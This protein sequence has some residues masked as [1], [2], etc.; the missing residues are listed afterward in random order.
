VRSV[1]LQR[2]PDLEYI[3]MDGGSTD[4]TQ[5]V[6][7]PYAGRFAHYVSEKDN[8]QADAL[9]RGFAL[10][11][12]EYMGYLNSDDMLAP[13]T[14]VYIADYFAA[15]PD[16][17]V[18]Y[19][20]R[21]AVNSQ[22][23]VIWYWILPEHCNYRMLRWDLIPQ[24]TCF[25]RRRIFEKCGNINPEFHFAMDYDLFARF[26]LN[27]KFKRANRFLGCFRQHDAAK[28]STQMS[29]VGQ[30]EIQRVW[31][32]YGIRSHKWDHVIGVRFFYYAERNGSKYVASGRSLPGGLAGAGYDYDQVWGGLLR[33]DRMPPD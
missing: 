27:G 9:H 1:L 7:E 25:W 22:N 11:T 4:N 17:D 19:S 24:E 33:S 12:G 2:Y 21:C 14:L 20:H 18:I 13:N 6:L 10:A 28:T 26:M 5:K 15:H 32:S 31:Q 30:K 16:V 23:Q 3:V 8:G 29:T